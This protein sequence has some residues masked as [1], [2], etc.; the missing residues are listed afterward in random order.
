MG[1]EQSEE[2]KTL[3]DTFHMFK[4]KNQKASKGQL[5]KLMTEEDETKY[6]DI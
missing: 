1:S 2:D 4:L 6:E 3:L 5:L